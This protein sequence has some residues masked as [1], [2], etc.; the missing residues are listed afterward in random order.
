MTVNL[1]PLPK[2]RFPELSLGSC[3]YFPDLEPNQGEPTNHSHQ[4]SALFLIFSLFLFSLSLMT[5]TFLEVQANLF[6]GM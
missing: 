2:F 6:P 5:L 3:F 4:V 1:I